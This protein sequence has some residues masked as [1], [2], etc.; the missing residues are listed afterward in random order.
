M[1]LDVVVYF[2]C[3]IVTKIIYVVLVVVPLRA[4]ESP[5]YVFVFA[6]IVN[7]VPVFAAVRAEVGK[8]SLIVARPFI[9]AVLINVVNIIGIESGERFCVSLV[10]SLFVFSSIVFSCLIWRGLL[11]L[12]LGSWLPSWCA[13]GKRGAGQSQREPYQ[14]GYH[15]QFNWFHSY[16]FSSVLIP[17][18]EGHFALK[19]S[20]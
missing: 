16:S 13:S 9:C 11:I 4:V 2:N 14:G 10:V 8:L 5:G 20:R 12:S 17:C 6:E 15:G 18:K 1:V 3:P 7:I 19:A